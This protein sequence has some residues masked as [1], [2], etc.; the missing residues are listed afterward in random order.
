[1]QGIAWRKN[2]D[3]VTTWELY[4]DSA[5]KRRKIKCNNAAW[6]SRRCQRD[7]RQKKNITWGRQQ[8][9]CISQNKQNNTNST[10]KEHRQSNTRSI[11]EGKRNHNLRDK[12]QRLQTVW[13]NKLTRQL[14]S[15][16]RTSVTCTNTVSS[17]KR[18][19][20][21][22]SLWRGGDV[23]ILIT[24]SRISQP[25]GKDTKQESANQEARI[26]NSRYENLW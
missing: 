10:E 18:H 26:L 3:T 7:A 11:Y 22:V 2:N 14:E 13:G 4:K 6:Q 8:F 24:K 15:D 9:K 1:M 16:E 19:Q 12:I 23:M 25:G 20:D 5:R 17:N 21:Y